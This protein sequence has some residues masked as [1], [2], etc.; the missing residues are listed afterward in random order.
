V[1][2]W[3]GRVAAAPGHVPMDWQPIDA[4]EAAQ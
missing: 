3:L 1:R 4:L 2:A